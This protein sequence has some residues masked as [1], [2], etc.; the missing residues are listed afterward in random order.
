MAWGNQDEPFFFR[1]SGGDSANF[2]ISAKSFTAET[3]RVSAF[4]NDAGLFRISSMGSDAGNDRTSALQGDAGLIRVSASLFSNNLG[5]LSIY[6]S[7]SVS[8]AVNVKATA[9]ALYGLD[10]FSV[11]ASTLQFLKFYNT[12]AIPTLG[13]DTPV[14]T[15]V[16]SGNG[17]GGYGQNTYS[18]PLGITFSNGIAL[19]A[20]SG[21]ADS[22][23]SKVAASAVVVNLYYI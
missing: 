5:S 19:G 14:M 17:V 6:R 12:S 20:V 9:G 18:W 10:L 7:I 8:S 16:V 21:L 23:A 3:F 1:I 22:F 13:T 11:S 2:Q 4:S 15:F